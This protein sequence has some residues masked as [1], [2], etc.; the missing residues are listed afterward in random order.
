MTIDRL[1]EYV[2]T[3]LFE[4][5]SW[6]SLIESATGAR[7]NEIVDEVANRWAGYREEEVVLES[8]YVTDN[9]RITL[10]D[11]KVKFIGERDAGIIELL[12]K[13]PTVSKLQLLKIDEDD[14]LMIYQDVIRDRFE[15]VTKLLN[16]VWIDRATGLVVNFEDT[17]MNEHCFGLSLTRKQ[18]LAA[19]KKKKLSKAACCNI[20]SYFE[21]SEEVREEIINP[22]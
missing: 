11:G 15:R 6:D 8:K 17:Y 10:P 3:K 22:Q 12:R 20:I 7:V 13:F 2:A 4:E 18:I 16:K 1:K 9:I 5:A 14:M 19:V 21:S